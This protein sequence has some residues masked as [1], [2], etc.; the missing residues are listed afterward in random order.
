ML[1]SL[2]GVCADSLVGS[3][4]SNRS[5]PS[6]LQAYRALD[7][8]TVRRR[9]QRLT[10]LGRFPLEVQAFANKFVDLQEKRHTADYNPNA[11]FAKDAVAKDIEDAERIIYNF[12][13]APLKDRRAFAVYVLLN[14]RGQ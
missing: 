2:A 14:V 12:G 8:G 3:A 1:H 4:A 9:C 10:A 6:W 7:H 11:L 5:D 13:R